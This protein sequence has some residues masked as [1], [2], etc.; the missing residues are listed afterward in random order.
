MVTLTLA[1]AAAI[2]AL[3]PQEPLEAGF[4]EWLVAGPVPAISDSARVTRDYLGGRES[5]LAPTHGASDGGLP[6]RVAVADD[7]GHLNFG[8]VFGRNVDQAVAYAAQ[9]LFVPEDRTYRLRL[10]SDDDLVI[11]LNGR[12]I[13]VNEIARSLVAEEDSVVVRLAGGWNLLLLKVINQHG[14]FGTWA[15]L[16][17]FPGGGPVRELLTSAIRPREFEMRQPAPVAVVEAVELGAR[18]RIA[19]QALQGLVTVRVRPWGQGLPER[20]WIGL[21]GATDGSGDESSIAGGATQGTTA[22]VE[23]DFAVPPGG[24]AELHVWIPF[25]RLSAIARG[26]RPLTGVATLGGDPRTT[27]ERDAGAEAVH[28][29]GHRPHGEPPAHEERG[30]TRLD[31]LLDPGELLARLS[32]PIDLAHVRYLPHDAPPR[33]LADT[34]DRHWLRSPPADA[35]GV[36][37]L[38]VRFPIPAELDALSLELHITHPDG[39]RIVVNGMEVQPKAARAAL[40]S[41]CARGDTIAA[42]IALP[43][44]T[45]TASH[46]P[47]LADTAPTTLRP[48]TLRVRE[49]GYA[50]VAAALAW[51]RRMGGPDM[52]ISDADKSILLA[53]VESPGKHTYFRILRHYRTLY[54]ADAARIRRDTLHLVG[55]SHIDAAW[56]W[57]WTEAVEV[58]RDTWRSALRIAHRF[59][60]FV[61]AQGSAQYYAWMEERDPELFAGV[62]AAVDA[63]E[64]VPVGGWWVEPDQNLPSGESLVRQGLYGQR[65]FRSRFGRYAR[66]AWTPDSFGYAWTLPQILR[67][68]G[69][70]FFV[71]QKLRWNDSTAFPIDVFRWEAPDG[72]S[73]LAYIPYRYN[74]NLEPERLARE[75]GEYKQKTG[76]LSH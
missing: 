8:R 51:W 18:L 30:A 12:R 26:G 43:R 62:R 57:R 63:G 33:A 59:P 1:V 38:G 70:E 6:W 54:S 31:R 52:A 48:P 49:Y 37:A 53:S 10:R 27:A 16:D 71:T 7:D 39:A 32:R 25:S 24:A 72:T 29:P 50:E 28:E 15:R 17:A 40:C 60:G 11:H 75:L 55:N 74:D 64:W 22:A 65:Y 9:Y 5:R 23:R 66:V 35:A 69:F 13:W 73:V 76:G 56:L 36:A 47:P 20:M 34:Q 14:G 3:H 44:P 61:Y 58:V 45:E 46:T 67:G 68:Q 19:W 42:A 2:H 21:Q 4:R 41:P